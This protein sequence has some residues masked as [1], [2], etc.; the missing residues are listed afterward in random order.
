MCTSIGGTFD[1]ATCICDL[2]DLPDDSTSDSTPEEA[3]EDKSTGGMWDW[4]YEIDPF[5]LVG[6]ISP[7]VA[8]LMMG[9]TSIGMFLLQTINTFHWFYFTSVWWSWEQMEYH[10]SYY[11]EVYS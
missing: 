9:G 5:N 7:E 8:D 11:W 2:T 1:D 3:S 4:F 10:P 6:V